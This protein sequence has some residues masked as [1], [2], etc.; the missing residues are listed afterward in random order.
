MVMRFALLLLTAWVSV[1]NVTDV[2]SHHGRSNFIYDETVT[3]EGKV[4]KMS[5][6]NPHVYLDVQTIN[7]DNET[8]IWLIESGT[9]VALSR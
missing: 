8:E 9:P 2:Y 3:I 7:N 1:L 4:I 5:W 6:R